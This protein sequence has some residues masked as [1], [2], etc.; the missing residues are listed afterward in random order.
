AWRR[1]FGK[2]A[3][4][5]PSLLNL[6]V[7]DPSS[8]DS[9]SRNLTSTSTLDIVKENNR[10]L[11]PV[12]DVSDCGKTCAVTEPSLNTEGSTSMPLV[13]I[14]DPAILPRFTLSSEGTWMILEIPLLL[15]PQPNTAFVKKITCCPQSYMLFETLVMISLCWLPVAPA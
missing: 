1:A 10:P 11:I 3:E 5:H 4:T 14:E 15:T 12:F 8:A 2:S 7:P 13:M 9:I 6:D